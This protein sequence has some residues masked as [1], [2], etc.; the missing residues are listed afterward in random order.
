MIDMFTE[1]KIKSLIEY[2]KL[3]N[4]TG[5]QGKMNQLVEIALTVLEDM[6]LIPE[7]L[8]CD[9]HL[10]PGLILRK[11]VST[12]TLLKALKRRGEIEHKLSNLS[13]EEREAL[14]KSMGEFKRDV[15]IS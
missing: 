2:G 9:V 14:K 3:F 15:G 1:N 5:A 12:D 4:S 11:G 7:K 6:P 13:Q 10:N 8:P